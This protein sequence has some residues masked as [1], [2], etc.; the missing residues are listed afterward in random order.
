MYDFDK[1]VDMLRNAYDVPTL[2]EWEIT[3]G[4]FQDLAADLDK[5]AQL[6][7][8]AAESMQEF[9]QGMADSWTGDME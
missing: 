3:A 4:D 8:A 1:M 2:A 6:G 7:H 5:L 9:Y